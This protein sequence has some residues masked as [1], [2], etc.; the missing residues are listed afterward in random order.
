MTSQAEFGRQ[1]APERDSIPDRLSVL[2]QL[3]RV[4]QNPLFSQSKRYP[5]VLRYLVHRVLEGST[6]GELKERTIGIEVL[7]RAPDYDTNADPTVRVVAGEIRKR[8]ILYYQEPGHERDIRIELAPGSY[9]PEISAPAVAQ[10]AVATTIPLIAARDNKGLR[11]S[12][13][14]GRGALAVGSA[15]LIALLC[16]VWFLMIPHQTPLDELWEPVFRNSTSAILCVGERLPWGTP[17]SL[18]DRLTQQSGLTGTSNATDRDATNDMRR[19][20][21][22]QPAIPLMDVESL[23]SVAGFIQ[24]HGVRPS[25]RLSRTTSL[26]ELRQ[27]PAVLIGGYSNYWSMRLGEDLRFRFQGDNVTNWIGDSQ[28]P[29]IRDW[30]VKLNTPYSQVNED[31]GLISRIADPITGHT[32]VIVAGITG[33]STLATADFLVSPDGWED[34]ARRAPHNWMKENIQ[35]VIGMRV[36][37]GNPGKPAILATHFW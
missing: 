5:L 13:I 14:R 12:R 10:S 9:T 16:L 24:S 20:I 11:E 30:S 28:R 26:A 18:D 36:I 35:I 27:I 25:V 17:P 15:A 8:L 6:D 3:E 33:Q 7:G 21:T 32:V 22:T 34:L 19:F 23:T 37:N 31:Y 1:K 29:G 4:V 2:Q